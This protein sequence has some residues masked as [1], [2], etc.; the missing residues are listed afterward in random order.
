VLVAL[1][2]WVWMWRKWAS[3]PL[4]W[5]I[6]FRKKSTFLC[7]RKHDLTRNYSD[8]SWPCR[9]SRRLVAGFPTAGA[10]V[11]AQVRSYGICGGQSDTGAGF[12]RILRFPLQIIPPIAPHSSFIMRGWYNRRVIA[13]VIVDSVP[14]HPIGEKILTLLVYLCRKVNLSSTKL[15]PRQFLI[16]TTTERGYF[17]AVI[18]HGSCKYYVILR[19]VAYGFETWS[20]TLWEKYMPRG[21]FRS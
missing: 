16:G 12:F 20:L 7:H 8:W 1:Q 2:C 13:S 17:N 5:R 3:G 4:R 6:T 19:V 14:F 18:R 21:I 11:R 10:R 9:S 15:H